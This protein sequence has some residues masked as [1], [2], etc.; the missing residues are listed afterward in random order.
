MNLQCSS[1]VIF[2]I[3]INIDYFYRG[4]Q[5]EYII[6]CF[7]FLDEEIPAIVM[8][9]AGG[10]DLHHFLLKRTEPIGLYTFHILLL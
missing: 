9:Y 7:Q 10:G 3:S 4:N 2:K 6:K 1:I 5:H 8:E